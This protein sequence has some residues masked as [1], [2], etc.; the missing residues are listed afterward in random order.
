LDEA[1]SISEHLKKYAQRYK[2]DLEDSLAFL[3]WLNQAQPACGI[4]TIT[5]KKEA[6]R[7]VYGGYD[8]LSISGSLAAGGRFNIGGAQVSQLFPNFS[9]RACLYAAS[10]LGCARKEAGD[11]LGMAEEY[12]ITPSLE[13]KLWD[14][15][16]LIDKRILYKGLKG[17]VDA[18]PLA[19]RWELQKVPKISQILAHYLRQRGGHGILYPSTKDPRHHVIAFF[20]EDDDHAKKRFAVAKH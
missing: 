7:I 20:I 3:T 11:L 2:Q 4:P 15:E 18:S 5:W 12:S 14:L 8:P 6:Y 17:I 19:A 1:F 10:H 9:M 16:A 13:L